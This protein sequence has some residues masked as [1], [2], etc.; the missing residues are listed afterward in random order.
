MHL[1]FEMINDEEKDHEVELPNCGRRG[2]EK[3][4]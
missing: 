3:Y 4:Q 1:I 2:L